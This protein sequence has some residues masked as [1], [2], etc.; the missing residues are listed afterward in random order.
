MKKFFA[1]TIKEIIEIEMEA[2]D[3]FR[4][5]RVRNYVDGRMILFYILRN[6]FGLTLD[7]IGRYGNRGHDTVLYSVNNFEH[8]IKYDEKLSKVYD[9]ANDQAL[10]ILTNPIIRKKQIIEDMQKLRTEYLTYSKNM[11]YNFNNIEEILIDKELSEEEKVDELFKVD[12]FMYT[13]MGLDSTPLERKDV[14]T[15]SRVIYRHIAKINPELGRLLV[16]NIDN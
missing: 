4:K 12:C 1:D 15:R 11:E 6:T 16:V 9:K 10:Y 13:N 2:P 7:A 3:I 5:T 14:S 8:L